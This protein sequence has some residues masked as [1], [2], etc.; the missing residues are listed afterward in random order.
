MMGAWASRTALP[1]YPPVMPQT[2]YK[3]KPRPLGK[4]FCYVCLW[5]F[6]KLLLS[7]LSNFNYV[8]LIFNGIPDSSMIYW[9]D[10]I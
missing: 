2:L 7:F 5:R 9:Y 1:Y 3:N 10:M 4:T 6:I 8:I